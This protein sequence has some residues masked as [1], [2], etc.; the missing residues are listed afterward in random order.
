MVLVAVFAVVLGSVMFAFRC[1][2]NRNYAEHRIKE[3][4]TAI[5]YVTTYIQSHENKS[6]EK[7][8]VDIMRRELQKKSMELKAFDDLLH[9]PW[10]A[11]PFDEDID[12]IM[13]IWRFERT[14]DSRD[15]P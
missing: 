4:S 11:V 7:Y 15:H 6:E 2:R 9:H 3:L 14:S 5:I 1:F 12:L 8:R 10:H 13:A